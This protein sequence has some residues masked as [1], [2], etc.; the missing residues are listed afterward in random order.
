MPGTSVNFLVQLTVIQSEEIYV[1]SL[2]NL[3]YDWI[4][5]CH[6]VTSGKWCLTFQNPID[7]SQAVRRSKLSRSSFTEVFVNQIPSKL[8]FTKKQFLKIRKLLHNLN[9][10]DQGAFVCLFIITPCLFECREIV[11]LILLSLSYK[12][13]CLSAYSNSSLSA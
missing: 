9:I 1:E 12:V 5:F 4:V 10:L 8:L 11:L 2:I 13:A 3:F 6:L 7:L